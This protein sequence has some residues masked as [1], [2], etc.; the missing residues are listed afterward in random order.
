MVRD[1]PATA[2]A[3]KSLFSTWFYRTFN[4]L[5]DTHIVPNAA[6]F[7][8]VSR[9][10]LDVFVRIPERE[11]FIRAL[12]PSLGFPQVSLTFKQAD[13]IHGRPTYTFRSSLRLARKALFDYSTV[14]LQFVF[15]L[16][17]SISILSFSFGAG[18]F[19]WKL[20]APDRVVAG[21]TDLITAIFFTG[22]CI[23][24]S[25]GILGR[26]MMMVLDQGPRPAV[27]HDHGS[28]QWRCAEFADAGRDAASDG[29]RL[30]R[31]FNRLT[32][33]PAWT[34]G[35]FFFDDT[36]SMARLLINADDLGLHADIDRGIFDC[37]EAGRVQSVSFSAIGATVDWNKLRE[38]Q[39]TGV[40]V[41]LHVTLVGEP[42]ATDGRLVPGWK[43]LVKSLLIPNGP[44][45]AM[46]AAEVARQFRLCIDNGLPPATLAHVDSHQH[47]HVFDHIWQPLLLNAKTYG[48]PRVRIPWCPNWRAMKKNVG[49]LALQWIS[50]RRRSEVRS[51]L[52]C[53]GLAYAGHNTAD[54][55]AD[56]LSHTTPQ[57][58]E[59]CVHPG[60]NT[61][62]L[63]S[64]YHD[65]HFDWTGERDA[66]LSQKFADA[67]QAAGFQMQ[68]IP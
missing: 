28:L 34:C 58:I 55:F 13:R 41:G 43:D 56:E 4:Q 30:S 44:M 2:G 14:P 23:L 60:V 52:P 22:G 61:P 26:Y 49:G 1:D 45:Q 3:G 20:I 63:E 12:I 24:A 48:I 27:V 10:V 66:L 18:H 25:L 64:R 38:L 21:F 17:M 9:R 11:K 54:I 59:L 51:Y 32:P 40:R 36:T 46:V 35:G 31:R 7:R 37:I 47:V 5:S 29:Q 42:W 57:D 62:A 6:D 19:I 8:L 16:G 65:W 53:L 15:W 33:S 67:V 39:R 68:Q 50:R